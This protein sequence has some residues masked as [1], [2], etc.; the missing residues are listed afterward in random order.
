MS[1]DVR[2][3]VEVLATARGAEIIYERLGTDVSEILIR[4]GG[5]TIIG[6]NQTH[7]VTRQRFTIAHEL[8][9]LLLHRGRALVV[10]S[11]TVNLR[12][13]RSS[14]ATDLEE[15]EAN[16]FAAELLVPRAHVLRFVR[17]LADSGERRVPA[18]TQE[19]AGR[20]GVSKLA[21]EYRLSNLGLLGPTS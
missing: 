15:I 1:E 6:V 3:D 10:N 4:E 9:H 5:R 20:F 14:L 18:V 19:L 11:A 8:G 21:M 13:G 17:E 7:P 16:A 2:L 12:D